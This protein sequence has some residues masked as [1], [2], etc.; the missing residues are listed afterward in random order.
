MHHH[1][2]VRNVRFFHRIAAQSDRLNRQAR[3]T[4]SHAQSVFPWH[5]GHRAEWLVFLHSGWFSFTDVSHHSWA[6]AGH[7]PRQT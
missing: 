6:H 1:P 7:D 4:S 3:T 2:G 5:T